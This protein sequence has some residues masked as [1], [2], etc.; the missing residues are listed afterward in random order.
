[1]PS[2]GAR[3]GNAARDVET[4]RMKVGLVITCM[5]LLQARKRK[6]IQKLEGIHMP[7]LEHSQ[8]QTAPRMD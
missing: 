6:P 8:P 1:M 4:K 3:V 7:F 2:L 5:I